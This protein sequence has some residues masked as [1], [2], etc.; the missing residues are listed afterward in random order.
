MSAAVTPNGASAPPGLYPEPGTGHKR[1]GTR[2]TWADHNKSEDEKHP[3]AVARSQQWADEAAKR[4]D[5]SGARA[6][7]HVIKAIGDEL[8]ET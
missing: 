8:P 1:H 3:V 2:S 5:H 7:L 4:G 6:W